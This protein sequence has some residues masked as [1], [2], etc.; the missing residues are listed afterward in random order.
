MRRKVNV[1]GAAVLALAMVVSSIP[2]GLGAAAKETA[3]YKYDDSYSLG[4]KGGIAVYKGGTGSQSV[5]ESGIPTYAGSSDNAFGA[6][7]EQAWD[8]DSLILTRPVQ[9][10]T[11]DGEVHDV[12][13]MLTNFDF[14]A[15][16]TAID[17][18]AVDGKLYVYG[19]TEG[20][21]YKNGNM[22]DNGYNNHS[23]TILSTSDMVNWTDEGFCDT[24]NLTN[25]PSYSETKETNKWA[26]KAWAPSG[27]AFDGDGD[28]QDEYYLFHTNSGAVGY[29][30][31][32]SPTGP[33]RD[34]LKKTM[35]SGIKGVKW[36]FDPA[37]LR[38]D[39]GDAYVYFG[40]GV[41]NDNDKEKKEHPDG[42]A[43]PKTGR[44]CKLKFNE[45]GEA[46]ADGDPQEMDTFYMFEDSE[47]NQFNGKY[48]YSYC[49]N[50][51]V[52]AS[53]KLVKSGSIAV[54]VSSD[55]M[56][57]AFDPYDEN[58]NE[59]TQYTDDEGVYHHFLGTIL[60]NPSVI[61]GQSYNNH[62]HMQSYKGHD[63]IFYHS[64]VLN[65][66]LHRESHQYRNLHV[67]EIIID[68]ET[69][70]I[71]IDPSYEGAKQIENFNPYVDI[72]GNVKYINATTTSYSAGVK[73]SLSDEM[74]LAKNNDDA[75]NNGSPMVLDEINTGDWTKIQGVDLGNGPVKFET[76]MASETDMGAIEVFIDD[77]TK[78]ANRIATVNVRNTG[79]QDNFDTVATDITGS[80]TGVHDLYFVFRGE[81]YRVAAWKFTENPVAPATPTPTAT[82]QSTPTAAP[83][84]APTATAAPATDYSKTY[85]IA[86]LNY[87]IS[88]KGTATV[89]SP[90]KK[91]AKSYTIPAAVKVDGKSYKVTGISA[92]AFKG[93]KKL[94]SVTIGSNVKAIGANAFNGCPALKK[95]TVKSAVISSVGKNAFKGTNKKLTVKAPK[96]CVAKY[97]KT[98]KGKGQKVRVK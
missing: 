73:S 89:K 69:D 61:Y 66:S 46:F 52:P 58:G 25:E 93:C 60:D 27:L 30:M 37:V 38:D 43:H 6:E 31:S 78:A 10:T 53:E 50:F 36:C 13:S 11:A 75:L 68:A 79:D 41:W 91:T 63:Y 16:P 24:Q 85:S 76:V 86:G 94:A 49:V 40:G 71:S 57:I 95:I 64:T 7:I 72:K 32:D 8:A 55:P 84:Q 35:F 22:A 42:I 80:Y 34:P 54:Y 48:Y 20:I 2:F 59:R 12:E 45:N 98:F 39:K 90:V 17:N 77:P 83:T 19:T 70:E 23:L 87:K 28:G 65:N 29:V 97:K 4:W 21:D 82:V 81:D 44:V 1:I 67:D 26:S 51:S 5:A 9:Y 47:I 56:N 15:D 14:I 18:T 74:T 3:D 88:E 33:W 96:K 62:H 92:G